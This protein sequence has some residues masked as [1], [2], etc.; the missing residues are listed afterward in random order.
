[1]K[2]LLIDDKKEVTDAI[3]D[4]LQALATQKGYRGKLEID[5]ANDFYDALTYIEK[6]NKENT[7]YDVV[8][9]DLLMPSDG[10]KI[11]PQWPVGPILNGWS[12]LCQN[13]LLESANYHQQY[14]DSVIIVYSAYK[15]ELMQFVKD[16]K[17]EKQYAKIKFIEKGRAFNKKGGYRVLLDTVE[18]YLFDFKKK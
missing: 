17:L 7:S 11:N 1:M 8:I 3:K 18:P 2:I 15:N 13:I 10:L 12:F 4:G 14:I 9:S 5:A 16:N 6:T